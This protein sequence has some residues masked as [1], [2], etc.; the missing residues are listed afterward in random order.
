MFPYVLTGIHHRR[1]QT[2]EYC[3]TCF[4]HISNALLT[5]QFTFAKRFPHWFE[6]FY[7][8]SRSGISRPPKPARAVSQVHPHIHFGGP[9]RLFPIDRKVVLSSRIENGFATGSAR[10][11]QSFLPS[12]SL[13]TSGRI[14]SFASPAARENFQTPRAFITM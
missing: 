3:S 10:E 4:P 13:S 9:P 12:I 5:S 1:N 6:G 2:D 8:I 7:C 11:S 14:S